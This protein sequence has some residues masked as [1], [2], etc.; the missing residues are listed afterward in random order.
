MVTFLHTTAY[1]SVLRGY[2]FVVA[3]GKFKQF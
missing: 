2:I 1:K 3:D